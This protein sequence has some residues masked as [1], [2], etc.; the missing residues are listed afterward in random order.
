M[1]IFYINTVFACIFSVVACMATSL[2]LS[3]GES[4]KSDQLFWIGI[5]GLLISLFIHAGN[6]YFH[7]IANQILQK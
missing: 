6:E 5:G 7:R 3:Y 2:K 4:E 1:S